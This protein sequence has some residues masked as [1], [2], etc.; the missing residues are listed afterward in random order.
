V[1]PGVH[2][3]WAGS[4]AMGRVGPISFCAIEIFYKKIRRTEDEKWGFA[5]PPAGL[6]PSVLLTFL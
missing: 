4:T 1:N 2:P 3:H 5:L 6:V